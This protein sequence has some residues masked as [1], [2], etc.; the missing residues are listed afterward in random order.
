MRN[1]SQDPDY[2]GPTGHEKKVYKTHF[3]VIRT[4]KKSKKSKNKWVKIGVGKYRLV[5]D[6]R[7][8]Y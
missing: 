4:L 7:F 5:R 6:D 2:V 3:G 1:T 8:N